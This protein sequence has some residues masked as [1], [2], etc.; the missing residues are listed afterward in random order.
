MMMYVVSPLFGSLSSLVSQCCY[1]CDDGGGVVEC[2]TCTRA[3]CVDAGQDS[4]QVPTE[5]EVAGSGKKWTTVSTS[6]K[7]CISSTQEF[8]EI[9]D[10]D[11]IFFCPE[12]LEKK[13]FMAVPVSSAQLPFC[14]WP[15]SLI[16]HDQP[17][18]SRHT[19]NGHAGVCSR[20]ALLSEHYPRRCRGSDRSNHGSAGCV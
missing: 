15:E 8:L 20:C 11:R 5:N 16:V 6:A 4:S 17:R 10:E 14:A 19:A 1:I 13:P 2:T 12:C 9:P 18:R 7:A 3:Y